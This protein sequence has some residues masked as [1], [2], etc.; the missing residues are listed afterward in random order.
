MKFCNSRMLPGQSYL[1]NASITSSG[2]CSID[3]RWP[4]YPAAVTSY[5]ILIRLGAKP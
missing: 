1:S 3:L 2:T 4:N 5:A